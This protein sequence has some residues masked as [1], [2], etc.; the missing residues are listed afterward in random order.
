MSTKMSGY[1]TGMEV[2]G[3]ST[4]VW[5][6]KGT[7]VTSGQPLTNEGPESGGVILKVAEEILGVAALQYMGLCCGYPGEWGL[8]SEYG[9]LIGTPKAVGEILA[10][11]TMGRKRSWAIGSQTHSCGWPVCVMLKVTEAELTAE[12]KVKFNAVSCSYKN[13]ACECQ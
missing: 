8:S 2:V 11:I 4:N 6:L 3:S 13:E 1:D 9:E 7:G 10:T 12:A 5:G